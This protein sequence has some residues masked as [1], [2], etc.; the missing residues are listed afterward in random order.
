L[1]T[2]WG[3]WARQPSLEKSL[4]NALGRGGVGVSLGLLARKAGKVSGDPLFELAPRVPNPPSLGRGS[5]GKGL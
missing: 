3:S 1:G 2:L 4:E 5:L